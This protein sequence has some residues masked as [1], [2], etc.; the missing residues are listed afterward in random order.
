MRGRKMGDNQK[1]TV[2]TSDERYFYN[3]ANYIKKPITY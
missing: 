1:N 3:D 2:S